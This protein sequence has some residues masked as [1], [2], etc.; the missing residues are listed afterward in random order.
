LVDAAV[1]DERNVDD[2]TVEPALGTVPLTR[3]TVLRVLCS[4]AAASLM[5]ACATPPPSTA[6]PAATSAATPALAPAAGGT[7]TVGASTGQLDSISVGAGS[8]IASAGLFVA[9]ERGYFADQRLDVNRIETTTQGDTLP[10]I[11]TGKMD[12]GNGTVDAF[13]LNAIN[14][15][16]SIRMVAGQA[17]YT[18]GHGTLALVVRKSLYDSGEIRALQDLK[19]RKIAVP[20]VAGGGEIVLDKALAQVGLSKDDVDLSQLAIANMPAALQNGALDV[21]EPAEPVVVQMADQGIG[22]ILMYSDKMYPNMESTQW[23][24]SPQF[25]SSRPDVGVRFMVGLLRGARD[26]NNAF[27]TGK[28]KADIVRILTTYTAVK[29]PQL[30]EKMQVSSLNANGQL[31]ARN[32]QD[33][34]DWLVQ[35]GYVQ[36]P[37]DVSK[38]IDPTFAERAVAQI[39]RV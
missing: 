15:G 22:T 1:V 18:P 11:A 25:A 35:H 27:S 2:M 13:L 10:Q 29:D 39:G 16:V 30:Y 12:I 32:M 20:V 6:G 38:L 33:Q 36:Q 4:A 31:D 9:M 19:G 21:V 17:S 5:E 8:I 14:S 24:Y 34:V 28:D 3:R 37:L 23:V 7:P 26:F